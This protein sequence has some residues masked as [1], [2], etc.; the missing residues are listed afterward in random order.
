MHVRIF[1]YLKVTAKKE[2]LDALE[3][4]WVSGHNVHELTVFRAD[5]THDDLAV[6]F[7]NL[8]FDFS[9]MF[10]HQ[11]LKWRRAVDDRGT[12]LLN[13]ARTKGIGFSRKAE[14]RRRAFVGSQE[15]AGRPLRPH[16]LA[17]G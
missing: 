2:R 3:K 8:C 11:R 5:L 10:I 4:R 16:R 1:G 9:R 14:G 13:T 15:R 7:H 6:L 17:F 12:N